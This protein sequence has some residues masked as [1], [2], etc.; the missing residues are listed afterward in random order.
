MERYGSRCGWLIKGR[1]RLTA[2]TVAGPRAGDVLNM[3]NLPVRPEIPMEDLQSMLYAFP[4][5]YSA[6]GER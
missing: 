5:L 3:L 2:A 4:T 6:I 1:G